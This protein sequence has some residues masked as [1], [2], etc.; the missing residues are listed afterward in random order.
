MSWLKITFAAERDELD[1]ISECLE[2]A[3]AQAI[4]IEDAGDSAL[5][6]L[7]DGEAPV[8]DASLVTGLFSASQELDQIIARLTSEFAPE[9]LPEYRVESLPDQD[10]ERS[11]MDRFKPIQYGA[12]LWICPTWSDP[13]DPQ[14]TNVMLDPGLA[15]GSGTHETTSLCMQWLEK[16]AISGKSIIDFG[17]GSG[18][19]AIAALKLGADKALGIDIDPQA[20]LASRRN[21]EINHVSDRLELALPDELPVNSAADVVFANILAGTLIQLR[22]LLLSLV[23]D[24][25]TLVLSGVLA[26][27]EAIIVDVYQPGKV[28]QVEKDGDWLMITVKER[29]K[30]PLKEPRINTG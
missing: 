12:N 21:A 19:L 23:K 1:F 22:S 7:L 17:C 2:L 16:N 10:W 27:Q 18:I 8:W 28:L 24:H 3:S 5:F 26:A 4:T 30:E 20:I 9:K 25:G 15:F 11:W 29:L 6:D 13:P 14:A